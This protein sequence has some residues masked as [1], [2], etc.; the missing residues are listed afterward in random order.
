MLT[1]FA[2]KQCNLMHEED[3]LSLVV[4]VNISVTNTDFTT[5]NQH[6]PNFRSKSII[7]QKS[8]LSNYTTSRILHQK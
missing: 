7:K 3:A 2:S 1:C 5:T 4:T 8:G 6:A